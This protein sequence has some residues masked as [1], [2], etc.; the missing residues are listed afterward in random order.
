MKF[1]MLINK[2][3]QY[4]KKKGVGIVGINHFSCKY[5]TIEKMQVILL[6]KLFLIFIACTDVANCLDNGKAVLNKYGFIS[7]DLYFD[8]M[9]MLTFCLLANICGY[10]GV[11]KRMKKQPAY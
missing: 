4:S 11:L 7:S 8:I 10:F 6:F 2:L 1:Y 9:T 3:L 5:A